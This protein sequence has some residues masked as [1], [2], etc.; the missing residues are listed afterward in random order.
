[1]IA[2]VRADRPYTLARVVFCL[3]TLA[4]RYSIDLTA[5]YERK[6]TYNWTRQP[7]HGGRTM[8]DDR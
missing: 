4:D 1:V 7:L 3:V 2:D 6:M 8:R 5:E